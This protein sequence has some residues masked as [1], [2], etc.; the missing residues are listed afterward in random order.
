M[1]WWDPSEGNYLDQN[2]SLS[3]FIRPVLPQAMLKC[4]NG[5]VH[6]QAA[7]TSLA[8]CHT[9]LQTLPFFIPPPLPSRKPSTT[10][11]SFF[12]PGVLCGK[13]SAGIWSTLIC[14]QVKKKTLQNTQLA[15]RIR[16][17]ICPHLTKHRHWIFR[18]IHI[19]HL[20]HSLTQ[21]LKS[22]PTDWL[23]PIIVVYTI[24]THISQ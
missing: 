20:P 2:A 13:N 4:T 10:N 22:K 16:W 3:A 17:V 1:G 7:L 6:L 11:K 24:L 18:L 14:Y 19:L 9:H 12:F 23:T 5:V 8:Q 15:S 21:D